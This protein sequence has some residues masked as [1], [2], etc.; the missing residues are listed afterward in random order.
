MIWNSCQNCFFSSIGNCFVWLKSGLLVPM[1]SKSSAFSLDQ[2]EYFFQCLL[3]YLNWGFVTNRYP[4]IVQESQLCSYLAYLE[5]KSFGRAIKSTQN[6]GKC[7]HLFIHP[8]C[9]Q[10]A[11]GQAFPTGILI[12]S[13]LKFCQL[14]MRLLTRICHPLMTYQLNADL[15]WMTN[16]SRARAIFII[17]IYTTMTYHIQ[18]NVGWNDNPRA[19]Q[20]N[21]KDAS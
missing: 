3:F 10:H 17:F 12:I 9:S 21:F 16:S 18:K 19:C 8:A 1:T 4:T 11:M 7:T 20:V 5:K 14:V 13:C 15:L 6:Y 2:S